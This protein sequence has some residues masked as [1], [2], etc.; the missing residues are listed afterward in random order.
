MQY[1]LS[2]PL[3]RGQS[4]VFIADIERRSDIASDSEEIGVD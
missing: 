1:L 4:I 3:L 2:I